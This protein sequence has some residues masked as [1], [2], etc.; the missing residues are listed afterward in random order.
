[1]V[2]RTPAPDGLFGS[3]I[4]I[5]GIFDVDGGFLSAAGEALGQ[6]PWWDHEIE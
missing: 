5:V 6:R 4:P 3:P 1:M 2:P